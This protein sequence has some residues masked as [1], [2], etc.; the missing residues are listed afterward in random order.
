VGGWVGVFW[1][2]GGDPTGGWVGVFGG[3]GD[4]TGAHVCVEAPG[5]GG[6]DV[7][8]GQDLSLAARIMLYSY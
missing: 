2:G 8:A 7:R 6:G 4:P 5:G 1:G 3:G